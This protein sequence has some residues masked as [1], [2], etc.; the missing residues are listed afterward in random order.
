MELVSYYVNF[1]ITIPTIFCHVHRFRVTI[2]YFYGFV[3]VY[4]RIK[5][6]RLEVP[7]TARRILQPSAGARK[8]GAVGHS[9]FVFNIIF[10]VINYFI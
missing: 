9:K 8:I 7:S 2:L 3:W 1:A 5:R 6:L 10:E 4:I